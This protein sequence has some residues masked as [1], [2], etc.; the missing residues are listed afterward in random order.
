[1]ISNVAKL[2]VTVKSILVET[3]KNVDVYVKMKI[4]PVSFQTPRRPVSGPWGDQFDFR[5][6]MHAHLFYTLQV[7]PSA[8]MDH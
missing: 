4:G 7:Y 3:E 8:A 5:I 1:M 6:N 2:T